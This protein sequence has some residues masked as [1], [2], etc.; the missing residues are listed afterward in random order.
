MEERERASLRALLEQKVSK[1][2]VQQGDREGGRRERV[3]LR[4]LL[5]Q[6]VSKTNVEIERE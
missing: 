4:A 6:K 1:M 3:S 5:E 2:S